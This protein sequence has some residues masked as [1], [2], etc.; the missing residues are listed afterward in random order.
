MPRRPLL[1][2]LLP[3]GLA[4]ALSLVPAAGSGEGDDALIENSSF[5]GFVRRVLNSGGRMEMVDQWLSSRDAL[6]VVEGEELVHFVYRGPGQRVELVGSMTGSAPG[7]PGERL[8]RLPGTD[9]FYRGY[10]LPPETRWDYRFVVDGVPQLDSRNPESGPGRHGSGR[11]SVLRMPGSEAPA[12]LREP[13]G[14]LRGRL[15]ESVIESEALG[16][17]RRLTVYLPS[18]YASVGDRYPL[19]VVAN[20]RVALRAGL[21]DRTLDNLVHHTLTP[22]VAVF[23]EAHDRGELAGP[24]VPEYARLLAEELLPLIESRY[25]AGGTPESRALLGADFAAVAALYTALHFPGTFG[26][27]ALQSVPLRAPWGEDL[28]EKAG[29]PAQPEL[30]LYLD[31]CRWEF[32]SEREGFDRREDARRLVA[33]LRSRGQRYHG[34]ELP[35]GSGWGAWRERTGRILEAFYPRRVDGRR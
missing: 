31:W 12:H 11:V 35:E 17:R 15:E 1:P 9:L 26:R 10:V 33:R 5:A 29:D 2:S 32:R 13:V 28:L 8:R 27:L 24:R 23:V 30:D 22:I 19:V 7:D 6:P 16:G 3:A 14:W 4:V 21:Y 20:G 25:H 18:G 34:G